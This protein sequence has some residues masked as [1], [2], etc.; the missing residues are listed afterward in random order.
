MRDNLVFV[1]LALP[2]GELPRLVSVNGPLGF[3]HIDEYI[4]FLSYGGGLVPGWRDLVEH[5]PWR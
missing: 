2:V 1:S 3:I 4:A 5:T